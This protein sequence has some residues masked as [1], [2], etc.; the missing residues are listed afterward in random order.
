MKSR[1]GY[2]LFGVSGVNLQTDDSDV[3]PTSNAMCFDINVGIDFWYIWC[4]MR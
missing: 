3:F 4:C 1:D 2:S